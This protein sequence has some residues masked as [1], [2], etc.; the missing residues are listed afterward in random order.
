MEPQG[1]PTP[2]QVVAVYTDDGA[3]LAGGVIERS[4]D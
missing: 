1:R 3:V 2:G 4:L